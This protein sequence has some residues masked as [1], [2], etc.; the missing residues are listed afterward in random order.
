VQC[1]TRLSWTGFRR[2]KHAPGYSPLT[3]ACA[4]QEGDVAVLRSPPRSPAVLG[5]LKTAQHVAAAVC[6]ALRWWDGCCDRPQLRVLSGAGCFGLLGCFGPLWSCFPDG[7]PLHSAR[8]VAGSSHEQQHSSC[9]CLTS[10]SWLCCRASTVCS[11]RRSRCVCPT[12]RYVQ[13]PQNS[14]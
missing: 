9:R 4:G 11:I 14:R 10:S 2:T 8:Y 1:A 3:H 13:Q 7:T 5:T 6:Y 12:R